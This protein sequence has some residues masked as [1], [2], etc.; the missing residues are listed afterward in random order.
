[1]L[2]RSRASERGELVQDR[3][4]FAA[5]LRE[6]VDDGSDSFAMIAGDVA[7]VIRP[8]LTE[9]KIPPEIG[10]GPRLVRCRL[11]PQIDHWPP[12]SM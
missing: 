10:H 9:G 11:P 3:G 4:V 1:V 12:R 8:P 2:F 5:D 6:F 7:L